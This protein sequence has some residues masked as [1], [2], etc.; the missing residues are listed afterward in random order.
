MRDAPDGPGEVP[1]LIRQLG[2]EAAGLLS[3]AEQRDR[4]R[5]VVD[6]EPVRFAV[7][8]DHHVRRA[9]P[10]LLAEV[11]R[12]AVHTGIL[13]AGDVGKD[14]GKI[15]LNVIGHCKSCGRMQGPSTIVVKHQSHRG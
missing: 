9:D 11:G 6:A 3:D 5:V 14:D 7:R 8:G 15:E 13:R 12:E 4:V 10:L 1:V 2:P